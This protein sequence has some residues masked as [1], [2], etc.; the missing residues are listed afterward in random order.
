M[1][2]VNK[3]KNIKDNQMNHSKILRQIEAKLTLIMV[4]YNTGIIIQ[5]NLTEK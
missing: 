5:M 1:K 3:P 4:G 2:I